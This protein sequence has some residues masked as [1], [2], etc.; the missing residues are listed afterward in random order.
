MSMLDQVILL[1][2]AIADPFNAQLYQAPRQC[3]IGE[4]GVQVEFNVDLDTACRCFNRV[5]HGCSSAGVAPP[6]IHGSRTMRSG[7]KRGVTFPPAQC[8]HRI[9]PPIPIFQISKSSWLRSPDEHDGVKNTTSS[10]GAFD[11]LLRKAARLLGGP[12]GGGI[13]YLS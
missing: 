10:N 5:F 8:R 6:Q 1:R 13:S 12:S 4:D 2:S 11:P 9:Y 3:G 7:G